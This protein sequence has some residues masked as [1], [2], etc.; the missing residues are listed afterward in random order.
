[1]SFDVLAQLES[2]LRVK[3]VSVVEFAESDEYCGKILFPGQRVWLKLVFGEELDGLEEDILTH[4]I[5][6]GR[7]GGEIEISPDIRQRVEYMRDKG[8]PHFREVV[9]VGGRRSSKGF[10]TGIAMAKIMYD[11]LQLQDPGSYYGIDP[12]KDIYFNCV[13]GSQDQ[14]KEFQFADFTSTVEGCRA[15]QQNLVKSLETELRVATAA[16]SR[17]VARDKRRGGKIFKDIARLRGKALAANAGTLRGSASMITVIDEMAHMMVGESK[18]TADQVYNAAEPALAQFKGDGMM[19]LNSSPYTK[20]GKFFERYEV[21]MDKPKE[22]ADNLSMAFRYP[23]W[24]M[25]EGWQKDPSPRRK[26]QFRKGVPHVSPDWDEN[27]KDEDGEYLHPRPDRDAIQ[28][29]RAK[30]A[31]DPDTYKVERRAIWAEVVDA[32]LLP[33]MVDRGYAGKPVGYDHEG[34][35]ILAPFQSNWGEGAH[36]YFRYIAHLDPS[37]NTAGFGFALG[38][39]EEYEGLNG[40]A[41]QHVVFD[42]VKRWRPEQFPNRVIKW[43]PILDE[44]Q[45]LAEIFRPA[46]ITFDQYQSHEPIET[47]QLN[48]MAAGIGETYVNEIVATPESNWRRAETFKVALYQGLVHM[49]S[50]GTPERGDHEDQM[51]SAEELKFLQQL[52]T[53]SKYP[54]VDR[55]TAGP[56]QTK[57]MADCL[58]TVTHALIGNTLQLQR[59]AALAKKP[60]VA[61]APGGFKI[62]GQDAG[63]RGEMP[64]SQAGYYRYGRRGEQ[65]AT[66]GSDRVAAGRSFTRPRIGRGSRIRGY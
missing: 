31:A 1:M 22:E 52:N 56:V 41:T 60:L 37:S 10:V 30:E 6:G 24:A 57:D 23:S 8:F 49:P 27:E 9:M 47:L 53:N 65:M 17:K 16:D 7:N 3:K 66:S 39:V 19:F 58:M 25:Y 20:V 12:D 64:T 13:A 4:W 14:A 44:L 42:I 15:M 46:A 29:Q 59:A 33:E 45:W 48:L 28:D 11:T 43:G 38:H 54:K 21:A 50:I 62:G 5:N 55:Q 32:Y 35:L 40:E 34:K 2:S 51:W 26:A 36:N 63:G 18:G 61:G